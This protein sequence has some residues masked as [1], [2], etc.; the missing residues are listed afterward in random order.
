MEFGELLVPDELLTVEQAAAK[1]QTHPSTVRRML[2]A[3]ILPGRKLGPKWRVPADLLQDHINRAMTGDESR[4]LPRGSRDA[5]V[6]G[7]TLSWL[8]GK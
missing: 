7:A 5:L 2:Q 3:G 4:H 8:R 1:L 6:S